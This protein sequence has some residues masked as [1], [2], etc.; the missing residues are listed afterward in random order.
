MDVGLNFDPLNVLSPGNLSCLCLSFLIFNMKGVC[1]C[2]CD[3][4]SQDDGK[5]PSRHLKIPVSGHCGFLHSLVT[6]ATYVPSHG[7]V[8]RLCGVQTPF[9]LLPSALFLA[10]W[11]MACVIRTGMNVKIVLNSAN[12]LVP[13]QQEP[14]ISYF[15]ASLLC[16]L[17]PGRSVSILFLRGQG[18]VTTPLLLCVATRPCPY[19]APWCRPQ[20]PSFTRCFVSCP[21]RWGQRPAW[22]ITESLFGAKHCSECCVCRTPV[23]SHSQQPWDSG[24]AISPFCRSGS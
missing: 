22:S 16:W 20:D 19:A 13:L 10:S 23:H 7:W 18:E 1:V 8:S 2:V 9:R 21:E 12:V 3:R 11:A 14:S 4:I 17:L 24:A 5:G 15:C 6:C